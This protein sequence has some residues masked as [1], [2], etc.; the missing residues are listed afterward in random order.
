MYKEITDL[1]EIKTAQQVLAQRLR[2]EVPYEKIRVIGY[3]SGYLKTSVRYGSVPG[4]E[5]TWRCGGLSPNK[6]A[7][8]NLLCRGVPESKDTLLID[9]QFNV[10]RLQFSRK[11]GSVFIQDVESGITVLGHRGLVTRGKSR[12]PRERLI[13]EADI[14]LMKA[15]SDVAPNYTTVFPVAPITNNGISG[16]IRAFATEMRRAAPAIMGDLQQPSY[17]H[18]GKNRNVAPN[19]GNT[20]K[21]YFDEFS[22]TRTYTRRSEVVTMDCKHPGIVKALHRAI[23]RRGEH[24]NDS[25]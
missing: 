15:I 9:L 23:D 17:G 19:L 10:P 25:S 6:A 5:A 16:D 12:V 18:G 14:S 1:D 13:R 22:G 20:L 2:S 21:D 24:Y 8:L 3:P 4:A 11:H 7:Y